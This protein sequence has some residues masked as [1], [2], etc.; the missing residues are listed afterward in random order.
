LK[1]NGDL[2][3]R[4]IDELPLQTAGA[5][6]TG[7]S[8]GDTTI[9]EDRWTTIKVGGEVQTTQLSPVQQGILPLNI[10]TRQNPSPGLRLDLWSYDQ[11]K[12]LAMQHGSYFAIDRAGLLYPEGNIE[13]GRGLA[14]E[15]ALQS[16]SVGDQR[17]L[18]FIDTMDRTTPRADNL[19]T[20]VLSAPYLEGVIVVQGHVILKPGASSQAVPVLSPP[21]GGSVGPGA[22]VPVQLPGVQLNGVLYA[23]GNITLAAST[24]VYGAVTAEGA[25]VPEAGG[26]KLE[27][28][29]DHQ[30]SQ[31][32]FRGVPVVYRA[33][34]TW[35]A[36]Y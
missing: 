24:K 6:V 22:R 13:P 31:G 20:V 19:G 7:Q 23:A 17:G 15:V 34:G 26:G 16:R 29:Y 8:Y 36:R 18:I 32:L 4:R 28:W 2:I 9:R 5:P 11:L 25:I 30:M 27:V 3:L 21:T 12:R 35:M 33:P 14:P 1:V 10:Q